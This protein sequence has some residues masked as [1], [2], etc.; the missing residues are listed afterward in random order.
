MNLLIE[1]LSWHLFL[2]TSQDSDLYP[3]LYFLL[4]Q[5]L[6]CQKTPGSSEVGNV[7]PD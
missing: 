5:E 1:D 6:N 3:S 7:S 4:L 2:S